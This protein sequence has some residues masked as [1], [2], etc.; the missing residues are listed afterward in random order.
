MASLIPRDSVSINPNSLL[1][2]TDTIIPSDTVVAVQ[3]TKDE[4]KREAPALVRDIDEKYTR[5][6]NAR[7]AT[8]RRWLKAYQN[9]RGVY[10]QVSLSRIEGDKSRIFVKITKMKVIAA[11]G[12]L[13]EV[14]FGNNKFPLTIDPTT[15]PEG[16]AEYVHYDFQNAGQEG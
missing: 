11:F 12:Q 10:D 2:M 3:D 13:V 5:A 15:V 8:E 4:E 14:L 9:Y 1:S 16:I 7:D 6:R